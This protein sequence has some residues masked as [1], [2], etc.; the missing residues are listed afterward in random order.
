M[1]VKWN[2]SQKLLPKILDSGCPKMPM[3]WLFWESCF[4]FDPCV[5]LGIRDREM[6]L[7]FHCLDVPTM[8]LF[9]CYF[10]VHNRFWTRE[11]C[12][13]VR[14]LN[15]AAL[16]KGGPREMKQIMLPFHSTYLPQG[17]FE[18]MSHIVS[19]NFFIF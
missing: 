15:W 9:T 17:R 2:N 13:C 12:R 14:Y 4:Y 1:V 8:K 3:I 10:H 11:L 6:I 16:W 18:L 19:L 7:F 5:C